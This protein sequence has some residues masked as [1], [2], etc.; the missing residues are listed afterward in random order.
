MKFLAFN[1]VVAA[2]LIFLFSGHEGGLESV[3]DNVIATTEALKDKAEKIATAPQKMAEAPQVGESQPQPV[4]PAQTEP[5]EIPAVKIPEIAHLALEPKVRKRREEILGTNVL[6]TPAQEKNDFM[7]PKER[8]HAL[9]QLAEDME[10]FSAETI[11][12]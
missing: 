2:A 11:S 10:Y 4:I 5:E 7:N 9:M 1:L 8:R 12:R 6:P 3:K